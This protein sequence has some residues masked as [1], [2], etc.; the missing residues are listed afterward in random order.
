MVRLS[1]LHLNM[2]RLH[3]EGCSGIAMVKVGPR[4]MN[5]PARRKQ[6]LPRSILHRPR[7]PNGPV[8]QASRCHSSLRRKLQRRR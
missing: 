2:L 3:V 7:P 1:E 6:G 4:P 8:R 5:A